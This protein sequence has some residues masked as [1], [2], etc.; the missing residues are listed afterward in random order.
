MFYFYETLYQ[1]S[2]NST[3]RALTKK[4]ITPRR[5]RL[6]HFTDQVSCASRDA[7]LGSK[8][9]GQATV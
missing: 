3:L 2:F 7:H 5:A 4:M 1:L 9:L 8:K 6:L